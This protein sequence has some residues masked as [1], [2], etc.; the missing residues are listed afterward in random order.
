M[1]NPIIKSINYFVDTV[2]L[3]QKKCMKQII[4]LNKT[5]LIVT[6][7]VIVYIIPSLTIC[8]DQ[9]KYQITNN[10]KGNVN[11]KYSII[12][13]P[14]INLD[15]QQYIDNN[16]IFKQADVEI[17]NLPIDL[18]PIDYD[19]LSLEDNDYNYL[20]GAKSLPNLV[21]SITKIETV[22][23]KIKN[24]YFK[25]DLSNELNKLL[26]KEENVFE[27]DNEIAAGF[28]FDRSVD[29]VTPF[30]SVN[31]YEGLIDEFIGINLNTLKKS[32]I[33]EKD[34]INILNSKSEFYYKIRDC[35]YNYVRNFLPNK[36][37]T[38]LKIMKDAKESN[39]EDMK[40]I[41]ESLEK[42]KMAQIEFA[43]CKSHINLATYLKN[44]VDSP[45]Y[46]ETNHKE[47]QMLI[48]EMPDNINEYYD[49][50]ISQQKNYY[51]IIKIMILETQTFGGVR[52]KF[53]DQIKRDICLVSIF[54]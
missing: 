11:K 4:A 8:I 53:Y 28:F 19:I 25:G 27:S 44:Y 29:M 36:F 35:N 26:A 49:N 52:N 31:T 7:E 51:S 17:F 50:S 2:F 16:E 1:S 40:K 21:R 47:F 18:Y 42:V 6:P 22:F 5:N 39:E 23:G 3:E 45:F 14:K 32:N 34:T 20:Q 30:L 33:V 9:I 41:S 12:F 37:N 10:R 54:Y 15:C 24:K 38:L 43:P 13:I 46:K 48:N